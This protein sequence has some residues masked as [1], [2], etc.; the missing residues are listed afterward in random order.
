MNTRVKR[1]VLPLGGAVAAAAMIGAGLAA[2]ATANSPVVTDALAATPTSAKTVADFWLDTKGADL[3][4]ATQYPFDYKAVKRHTVGSSGAP[5]SD[6]KPGLIGQSTTP[7]SKVK[8]VNLPKTIGKVFFEKGGKT[9]WCSGS[10]IQSNYGNLVATAGHCVYDVQGNNDVMDKWVFVP[11]YYQ[12]KAPYGVYVGKQAFTHY[13]FDVYEDFD[14]N[15]AFVTVYNGFSVGD[16]KAVD[17][18]TYDAFNGHQSTKW[19]DDVPIT[20][21]EYNKIVAERGGETSDAWSRSES[22]TEV[23]SVD[24]KDYSYTKVEVTKAQFDAAT[25][26]APGNGS[27]YTPKA[28]EHA[29]P[30]VREVSKSDYDNYKGKGDRKIT[31]NGSF[32]LTDYYLGYWVK[33]AAVKHYK[34][35]YYIMGSVDRGTLKS[36]VG[37][38]GFAWNQKHGIP[39]F[40]FGYPG[41]EHPDGDRPFS[42]VTVKQAYGK[43]VKATALSLKAEE[44]VGIRSGAMT[45]GA[46]GGPWI[47]RY[48]SASRIGYINGVTGV[49]GDTDKNDRF[50]TVASAYFDGE[51][52]G[53]YD[54]AKALWSGKI[55]DGNGNIT[56]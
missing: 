13:D 46:D 6:G 7:S 16:K 49:I 30:W 25:V 35:V 36:N 26:A 8:N 18:K 11:A 19:T 17:K 48:S 24:Q 21:A 41:G 44:L 42:G 52:K 31:A 12:G 4:R 45:A 40:V 47:Y 43:T 15:Y 10:S 33:D 23:G 32:Q 38:Q 34:T 53:V 5:S 56:K 27:K 29:N 39:V 37:A 3:K 51:T 2:P 55:V 9:Y 54:K 50:D 20:E 1:L 28:G 14:K 22:S